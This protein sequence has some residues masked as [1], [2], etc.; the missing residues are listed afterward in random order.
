MNSL[1][2]NHQSE[3]RLTKMVEHC[4]LS[5][6]L[7]GYRELTEGYFNVAYEVALS[8]GRGVILK[9]APAPGARVMPYEKNILHAEVEAMRTV[10]SKASPSMLWLSRSA[11]V[12]RS[13]L[14]SS[15]SQDAVRW[16]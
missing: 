8:D 3:Q 10:K 4:F 12:S 11:G 9:V 16:H 6:K 14:V 15:V 5:C 13:V 1:T 7:M 2:K